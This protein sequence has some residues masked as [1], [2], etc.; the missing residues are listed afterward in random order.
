MSSQERFMAK[1][2]QTDACWLW[3]G[4]RQKNGYG[5]VSARSAGFP[6]VQLAHR[7]AWLLF[8]GPIPPGRLVLHRCDNPRCVRPGHLFLGTHAD[9]VADMLQKGRHRPPSRQPKTRNANH[10]NCKLRIEQVAEIRSRRNEPH[11]RLAVEFG[12]T[13]AYINAIVCGRKRKYA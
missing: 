1:V 7:L 4:Y 10:W 13:R 9:N 12:T 6:G 8:V 5:K 3:T 11:S 2:Q